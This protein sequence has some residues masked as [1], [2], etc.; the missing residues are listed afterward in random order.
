MQVASGDWFKLDLADVHPDSSIWF[1]PATDP[2]RV[3]PDQYNPAIENPKWAANLH[4]PWSE[5][6]ATFKRGPLKDA[7][8]EPFALNYAFMALHDHIPVSFD[9]SSK[10]LLFDVR[11]SFAEAD[12]ICK[13]RNFYAALKFIAQYP[14]YHEMQG[15]LGLSEGT[16]CEL[17]IPTI[18]SIAK[19]INFMDFAVRFW[20]WN[21]TPH[22][23]ERVLTSTDGAPIYISRSSNDFVRRITRS[24]KYKDFVVKVDLVTALFGLPVDYA[25]TVHGVMHDGTLWDLNKK[26]K[27]KIRAWEYSLG[28]KAYIGCEE[29]LT[30]FKKPKGGQLTQ[31][32]LRHN[33]IIKHYRGANSE[34]MVSQLKTPR[35]ALNS[36]WRNDLP[37]LAA[38]VKI[39]MHMMTLEERMRGPRFD[40]YGPWMA[41]PESILQQ[42]EPS[43]S[44]AKQTAAKRKRAAP[45]LTA[46][47]LE[48][49]VEAALNIL[50]DRDHGGRDQVPA[51]E[52][53]LALSDGCAADA[54]WHDIEHALA[55]MEKANKV[56]LREGMIH[57]I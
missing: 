6:G 24:G 27:K 49:M 9:R 34:G 13:K 19:H 8:A 4:G 39:S 18:Y 1:A 16:F 47:E 51:D 21:H 54:S 43:L 7:A 2:L 30:E 37:L 35:K 52:L 41:A 28:D 10:Q 14:E 29:M 26:R 57:I 12:F 22:F 53:R 11:S 33:Q 56:M 42:W 25:W 48:A 23:Q 3:W 46:A 17:I 55:S 45:A 44:A 20:D 50:F 40:H 32:Q 15:T 31:L 5:I 36:R 38:V